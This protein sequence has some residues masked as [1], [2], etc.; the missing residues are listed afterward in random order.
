TDDNQL[1]SID[2]VAN[3]LNHIG[4][5]APKKNHIKGVQEDHTSKKKAKS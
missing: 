1:I 5:E 4:K 3:P 2:N